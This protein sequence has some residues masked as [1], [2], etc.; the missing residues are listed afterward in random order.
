METHLLTAGEQFR[1]RGEPGAGVL[2]H[3]P[4]GR[5]LSHSLTV[6]ASAHS[7]RR[8]LQ[9]CSTISTF[10]PGVCVICSTNPPLLL[11]HALSAHRS[12]TCG[13]ASQ[14]AEPSPV[15][16]APGC[17]R[18]D[19]ACPR[20][21]IGFD[22]LAVNDRGARHRLP[23]RVH[24]DPLTHGGHHLLRR[25]IRASGGNAW[26]RTLPWHSGAVSGNHRAENLTHVHGVRAA[27][28]CTR[29]ITAAR[30]IRCT[31]VGAPGCAFRLSAVFC[32]PAC[33]CRPG[34]PCAG[35]L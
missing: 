21:C 4:Q 29:G 14:R 8:P 31:L 35:S 27:P 32:V 30:I 10:P 3:P 6:P 23:P 18:A 22:L 17:L 15:H 33:A 9:G 13:A 20:R 26:D 24:L 12:G 11:L 2:H 34:T 1:V 5:I 16:A 25:C 7:P 28:V 19:L